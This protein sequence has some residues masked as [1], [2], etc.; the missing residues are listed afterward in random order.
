VPLGVVPGGEMRTIF[1]AFV[2]FLFALVGLVLLIACT[3]VAGMLLARG[4]TRAREVAV[5]L[6]VGAGRGRIIRQLVTESVLLSVIGGGVGVIGAG[7]LISGLRALIPTLPVPLA[8]DLMLDWRV[9][10]FSVA[11]AVGTGF[12]FGLVPALQAADTDLV[13]TLKVDAGGGS[14]RRVRLRQ[15][16]VVAQV[17]M[18]VLL[19]VC[20]LLFVRSLQNAG[21]IDAGFDAANADAVAVD[22]RLAG[23]DRVSGLQA[24]EQFLSRVQALPAV[25]SATYARVLP[26]TGSGLG[27]GRLT[28]PGDAADSPGIRADWNVVASG[29]FDTMRS[30]LVRGR[31]FADADR[32]GRP[33]VAIV[34]ET[35]AR[36]AW[37]GQDALGKVLLQ[38]VEPG[39]P[40]RELAV[41]GV[42]R[43]AK[44]RS[45]GEEP[46]SFIF[47]PL[48][49]QFS[50]ELWLVA[51]RAGVES[52]IPEIRSLL[53]QMEPNLPI[54]LATSLEEATSLGLLP[55]RVAVWV[56]GG[57]GLVG[58][59]LAC[60]GIYGITAFTVTQR[61][62]EIGV[63]VA[64]GAT[65]RGVLHLV[66]GQAMRMALLG[67]TIGL[68]GA[69]GL[70]QLLASMLYGIQPIDPPSFALGAGIFIGL[71]LVS[72][73]L[74]ARR[75][76]SVNPVDA[77]RAQ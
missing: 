56:A 66:V 34:N 17:A 76:A 69:A 39:Q 63:R 49:Q 27:L 68:A 55:Q 37:P 12:L 46:M 75:A 72:S 21:Q 30:A 53:R 23:H 24:A 41:V 7:A 31:A 11:L 44:Y 3:N 73:W 57:F 19:V 43:D 48:A 22:F 47:V 60:I 77:L 16:F 38:E 54:T 9:V 59:L 58:L 2:G 36:R 62:R 8:V 29:Y 65:T 74:P 14:V 6:A 15:A 50:S 45:L 5:R 32:S 20:A 67:L 64:L 61:T 70:T 42:A 26:L 4:V 18:S 33:Y 71:S 28:R 35:L 52:A 10:A 13:S 25:R 1:G 40:P 51:R